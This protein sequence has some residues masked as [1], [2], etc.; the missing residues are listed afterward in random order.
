MGDGYRLVTVCTHGD[1]IM[2]PHWRTRPLA[3]WPIQ[4][5]YPITES[6]SPCPIL[7]MPSTRL[8]S[9]KYQFLSHCFDLTRIR[10]CRVWIQTHNFRNL[11][12]GSGRPAHSATPTGC[13]QQSCA[14][15]SVSVSTLKY[16]ARCVTP[17]VIN[18][19]LFDFIVC[20]K[21][22]FWV[23]L[24]FHITYVILKLHGWMKT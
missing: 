22:M 13:R 7:I 23:S 1:F 2:L 14:F 16:T 24:I 9:D 11:R 12:M 10:K 4:S 8:G 18:K 19:Y 3:P 20:A 15:V 5:H 21:K 6:T 17:V